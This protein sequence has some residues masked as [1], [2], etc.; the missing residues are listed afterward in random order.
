MLLIENKLYEEALYYP[1]AINLSQWTCH[2]KPQK[3]NK[4]NLTKQQ[5]KKEAIIF[6]DFH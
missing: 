1:S 4:Q 6:L 5:Q 2:K 3:T